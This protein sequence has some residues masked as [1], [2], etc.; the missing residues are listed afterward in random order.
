MHCWWNREP[1]IVNQTIPEGKFVTLINS[2]FRNLSTSNTFREQI[3]SSNGNLVSVALSDRVNHF[4]P[5]D[6]VTENPN[7]RPVCAQGRQPPEDA[8]TTDAETQSEAIGLIA[9]LIYLSTLPR[10]HGAM[11][12]LDS[13]VYQSDLVVEVLTE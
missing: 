9:D 7:Q 6:F 11:N 10:M 1:A 12:P 5:N 2:Q 3:T 13:V 4:G 8:F